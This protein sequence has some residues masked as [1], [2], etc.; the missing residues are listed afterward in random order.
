MIVAGMSFFLY[1]YFPPS[2]M[3]TLFMSHRRIWKLM[4]IMSRH[5]DFVA[6]LLAKPRW[7]W[8]VLLVALRL[9]AKGGI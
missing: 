1:M 6:K 7:T 2:T 3:G 5:K 8:R 4:S 9:A